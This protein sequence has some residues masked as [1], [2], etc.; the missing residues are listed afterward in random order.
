LDQRIKK[1]EDKLDFIFRKVESV[2]ESLL[3]VN[4]GNRRIRE[5]Q[6]LLAET[7]KKKPTTNNI[8]NLPK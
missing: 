1:L 8:N 5:G 4:A 3:D 7:T 2:E 6:I